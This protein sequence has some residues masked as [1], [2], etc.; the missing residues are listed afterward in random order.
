MNQTF[1]YSYLYFVMVLVSSKT[2]KKIEASNWKSLRIRS[3][4]VWLLPHRWSLPY[5]HPC[6]HHLHRPI[7]LRERMTIFLRQLYR[8]IFIFIIRSSIRSTC[9]TCSIISWSFFHISISFQKSKA[10]NADESW[11]LPIQ[12]IPFLARAG[13][14][15]VI[16]P[17]GIEK[18]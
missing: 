13:W 17:N 18:E 9:S 4:R 3:R 10:W 2:I 7:F 12:L 16:G 8:F 14:W 15:N 11:L 5:F 6:S 1:L